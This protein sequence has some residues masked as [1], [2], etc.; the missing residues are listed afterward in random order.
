MRTRKLCMFSASVTAPRFIIALDLELPGYVLGVFDDVPAD[1]SE[2][3][4][5][6]VDC[7][8][9]FTTGG[10]AGDELIFATEAQGHAAANTYW[11]SF[12]VPARHAA[13][14]PS[15]LIGPAGQ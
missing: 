10:A 11:V 14:A 6:G 5:L 1:F 15:G 2:D 9:F 8:L 7:V 3:E 13:T 4:R 12:L